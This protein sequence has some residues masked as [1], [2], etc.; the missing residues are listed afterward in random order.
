MFFFELCC[1]LCGFHFSITMKL[2]IRGNSIRLRLLRSEVAK[3]SAT[4]IFKESIDFGASKLTYILRR[5][6]QTTALSAHFA[7]N[8]ITVLIPAQTAQNWTET[9]LVGLTGEQRISDSETLKI[10]VEKDFVCL[11]RPDDE[12]NQ[13]AYPNISHKC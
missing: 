1:A 9:E 8:E 7:D 6:D 12:D 2:R 11:D 13:D 4:G 3:F 10:L 5:S